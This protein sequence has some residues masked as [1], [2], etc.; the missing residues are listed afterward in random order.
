MEQLLWWPNIIDAA[1]IYN[2][3]QFC[4]RVYAFDI[5]ALLLLYF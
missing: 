3:Q 4:K 1:L 5:A 2:P